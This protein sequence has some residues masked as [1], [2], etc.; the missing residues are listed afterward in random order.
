MKF[1]GSMAYCSQNIIFKTC[2]LVKSE[3]F[4]FQ[5]PSLEITGEVTLDK[6]FNLFKPQVFPIYS[7]EI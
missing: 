7:K 4:R 2:K 3:V 6:L 1:R 5:L